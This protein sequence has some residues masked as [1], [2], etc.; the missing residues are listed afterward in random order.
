MFRN[1]QE[2]LKIKH[3]AKWYFLLYL[4]KKENTNQTI[5]ETLGVLCVCV[6]V[7]VKHFK[8]AHY[9][10]MFTVT[11][12]S[13][14]SSNQINY[15][16]CIGCYSYFPFLIFIGPPICFFCV[17]VSFVSTVL[18]QCFDF[19]CRVSRSRYNVISSELRLLSSCIQTSCLSN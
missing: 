15:V 16:I 2:A 5:P 6:R 19:T 18:M 11:N 12:S 3:S 4:V 9:R 8:S 17:I 7:C 10:T 13:L 1:S 14:H